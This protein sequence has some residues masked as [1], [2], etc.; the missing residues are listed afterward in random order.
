MAWVDGAET[1]CLR[2]RV[3]DEINVRSEPAVEKIPLAS[4]R[5]RSEKNN[6][7]QVRMSAERLDRIVRI[8]S[9]AMEHQDHWGRACRNLLF[10]NVEQS[11]S[12]LRQTKGMK[13]GAD[14]RHLQA[15]ARGD[16]SVLG[17]P[18]GSAL[19]RRFAGQG[20]PPHLS[21]AGCVPRR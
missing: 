3:I 19:P 1:E 9:R 13:P 14:P 20:H 21:N 6:P 5:I 7:V 10:G 18:G 2:E 12:A 17:F 4:S 16:E 15:W 11:I 8:R